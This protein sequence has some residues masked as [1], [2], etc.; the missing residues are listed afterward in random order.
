MWINYVS[1][2]LIGVGVTQILLGIMHIFFKSYFNWKEDL[3]GVTLL[4][5][6][7][8]YVHTFFIAFVVSLFGLFTIF[9]HEELLVGSKMAMV[10]AALFFLF[11]GARLV[12]QFLVY[13]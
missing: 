6:Q 4:T 7:I 8:F 3:A 12:F 1:Y 5:R 11:W 9:C 10:V 2:S 13:R